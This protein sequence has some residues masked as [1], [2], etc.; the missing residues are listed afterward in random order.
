[1]SLMPFK[2]EELYPRAYLYKLQIGD[3][4][5]VH[6][7][8]NYNSYFL[9]QGSLLL[10]K[11]F[12]NQEIVGL[13]ILSRYMI[14]NLEYQD[15]CR[16]NYYYKLEALV[17][18]YVL[19]FPK[20]SHIESYLVSIYHLYAS[21][22]SLNLLEIFVHR[23]VKSRLVHLL[24]AISQLFGFVS[25]QYIKIDLIL[26]HSNLAILTGTNISTISKLLKDFQQNKL[27]FYQHKKLIIYDPVQLSYY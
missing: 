8:N 2:F 23:K 7:N 19:S 6:F 17:A 18:T 5:I 25:Q 15:I 9:I 22:K 16:S 26:S 1:M 3:S 13:N 27:I 20:N 14:I 11:T 4:M 24:L 12:S 21:D 10:S